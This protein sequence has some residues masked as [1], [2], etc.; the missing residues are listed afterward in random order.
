LK[1]TEKKPE[2]KKSP[3]KKPE[4]KPKPPASVTTPTAPQAAASQGGAL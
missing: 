3:E 2:E 1:K 4:E